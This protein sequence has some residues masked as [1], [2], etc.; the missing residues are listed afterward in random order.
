MDFSELI[1]D[2]PDLWMV[3]WQEGKGEIERQEV[4]NGGDDDANLNGLREE[5]Y[6]VSPYVPLFQQF[7]ERMQAK[8]LLLD[9][10]KKVQIDLIKQLF[11]SK[12][13]L[14]YHYIVAAGDYWWD[15]TDGSLYASTAGGLQSATVKLNEV[16]NRLNALIPN[17]NAVIVTDTN[18]IVSTINSGISA[19]GNVLISQV[20]SI[21][22]N[23]VNTTVVN[24][25]NSIFSALAGEI[26][27]EISYTGNMT[28]GYINDTIN[29]KLDASIARINFNIGE[30]TYYVA[31]PGLAPA[32][33][34]PDIPYSFGPVSTYTLGYISSIT[35]GTFS[36]VTAIRS[37]T[38]TNIGQ[39][40]PANA[41]W[42]PIGSTTPVN[43]T[44]DEQTAILSG[45]AERTNDLFIIK[46]QKI[47]EVNALTTVDDVIAYD[48]LAGWPDIP[49]PPGYKLE[50]PIS[51]I[52][53][54][55]TIVGTPS[56]GGG[57]GVPEAPSNG[58]YYARRNAAWAD[59]AS[60]FA[61][62]AALANY[63]PLDSPVFTGNA[64]APT[65]SPGDADTSIA[66]TGFV[67]TAIAGVGGGNVSNVGTPSNGQLA[68]WTDA[69]HIQGIAPSSLGFQPLDPDLTSL[70]AASLV[71]R[72][73]YRSA[74]NTWSG[75]VTGGNLT[76]SGGTLNAVVGEAGTGGIPYV[77]QSGGWA[78]ASLIF[79]TLDSP[80]LTGDP[81]APTP[82]SADNDTSIATTAFVKAQGYELTANKGAANGYASL[83]ASAKVPA[84]QLPSY[85]D[86][87]VEYA[88]LAAFPATGTVGVIYVALDTEKIYR[89]SGSAYVEISPSPGST[90]AVPEGSTNL[91]FTNERVDDRAAALIQNGTGI[92]WSYN[93]T[94]GTLTPTIT[95]GAG[96][97][98]P[99]DTELTALAGLA[100]AADRLPY[101][102]GAGTAALATFTGF[103]RSLVDDADAGTA[104]T[105]LG[106]STFVK[107][108]L[109]DADAAAVRTTI[110]AQAAG[111]YQPLDGDLT[112]L[113]ALTGTNVIYYRSGTDAWSSVTIGTGLTFTGGTLSATGGGGGAPTTAQYIVAATDATLSA[114]RVGTNSTS[115]TWDFGT[116]GQALVKRAALTGDVTAAADSNATTLAT[117]NSN[118]GTFQGITVNAKGLVTAA[119]NQNYGNVAGPG[120]ATDNAIVRFDLATGKVVQNS[121]VIIDDSNQIGGAAKIFVNH[122]ADL[123]IDGAPTRF[124]VTSLTATD[125]STS[126]VGFGA[127][128]TGASNVFAK[129]RGA[130]IATHGAVVN[131]DNL[132]MLWYYGSNGTTWIN[133]AQL[134][135]KVNAAP[136][137]SI[138]PTRFDFSVMNAAGALV[139]GA[140]F[141]ATGTALKGSDGTASATAGDVGEY[142]QNILASPVTPT[143]ST[144]TAIHALSLTAGD[145]DVWANVQM[146]APGGSGTG[147]EWDLS[148]SAT[149]S[150]VF[151][152]YQMTSHTS[153]GAM[154]Q[155][156]LGP[157][158]FASAS[159]ITVTLMVRTGVAGTQINRSM[160]AARRR[161]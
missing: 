144:V 47:G 56:D 133:A 131:G 123:T 84:A 38:W 139:I 121:S 12:R 145:W 87:V 153:A 24:G 140:S 69:T 107:T 41:Q 19:I 115:I 158:R 35:P 73:Y 70:A 14:P 23:G 108:I 10:A 125:W 67:V 106:I 94:A 1:I 113:A 129:S 42:I 2:D 157:F 62:L 45:I 37:L 53:G 89:W 66:T 30:T 71:D 112:A 85:V 114:E 82:A 40:V 134:N 39:V 92:T 116:A 135:V 77:R 83:D 96:P 161:R 79:A 93:D 149:L 13:Q 118:V 81:R 18:A 119:A 16:I 130:S 46:N 6:D 143:V 54:G 65:P 36:N 154:D 127:N 32:E 9:Q 74:A 59:I 44:P 102:N 78:D 31:A 80:V 142:Q 34:M 88:N 20:N 51:T 8:N 58:I 126:F 159:P 76:F 21:V 15:A 156:N 60:N 146:I 104:Q 99:L 27:D 155:I 48:V 17:I 22:V 132:G 90:D 148:A 152:N 86:D 138:I 105:T 95:A 160:I 136:S 98:Q 29:A 63:A 100:S 103:G 68:Q 3:H 122:T 128:A 11:E 57:G 124:Q 50:A 137:G 150:G 55:L 117:V 7:L 25:A 33:T 64:R 72:I 75:V 147:I 49:V 110:G 28:I 43:V 151:P 91:Y 97:F 111:N 5:F 109:D 141:A 61:T 52:G 26:N 120:S 101:F 4:V